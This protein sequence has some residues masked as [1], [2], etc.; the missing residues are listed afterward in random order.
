MPDASYPI[1]HRTTLPNGIRVVSERIPSVRSIAVGAWL[2]AGSRDEAEQDNG[3]SHFIEHMVFKGT[4]RRRTHHIAQRMEAVGGYLNAFTSKEYTCYYARALD[5]HLERALDVVIDL[6]VSPTLPEREVEKEKEVVVEEMKMYEDAPEDLIFDKFEAVLYPHHALGRP[7]LG[8]PE[9]VRSFTRERLFDYIDDH[10]APNRLVV[11]VAGNVD[12]ETVVRYVRKMT[13]DL[14]RAPQPIERTSANGYDAEELVEHRPIQQAHLIVGTRSPGLDDERRT[15]LTT[16]NTLLGGGMS[17][18]LS[19]NIREKYGYCYNI[20]S[21]TNM[22]ADTGDFGVY[23]GTDASKDERSRKLI[24]RELEKL[25]QKPVSPRALSQAKNQLKG[26]LML[27]LESMSNRMM[28]LGRIELAFGRYFTLDEVIASIDEVTA[29]EVQ[30]LA[31]ELFD[32]A[33]LSTVAIL[34]EG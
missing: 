33:R 15:V 7:V 14:E 5:E 6:V 26:S 13:A 3:I 32:P 27:G 23:M 25:V 18:R 1:F 16:L 28:R 12:H 21:F 30:D 10:Y 19:Q 20:Y 9:T 31:A 2:A 24:G 22:L 4:Q 8:V 17:S 29:E 11:A 34:P